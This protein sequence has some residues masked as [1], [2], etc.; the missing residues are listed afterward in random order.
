MP[1]YCLVTDSGARFSNQQRAIQ[2]YPLTI[3]PN[4]LQFGTQSYREDVDISSEE[5]FK[6][7][8]QQHVPPRVVAPT[9]QDYLD[10]YRSLMPVY[11]GIISIH[12][13]RDLSDSWKNARMASQQMPDSYPLLVVDSRQIC[14]GQGILVKLAAEAILEGFPFERVEAMVRAAIERIYSVYYVETLEY[15]R[16]NA[17]MSESRA[18]LGMMLGVKPFLSIEEGQLAVTEK[19]RTRAQAVEQIV[20]FVSEFEQLEDA[21]IVQSRVGLVEPARTIQ[22]RLSMAF[23]KQHFPFTLYSP[24]FAA[25]VGIEAVGVAILER[26]GDDDDDFRDHE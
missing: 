7:M 19:G 13:S 23:P 11:E 18:I 26:S 17:I 14:A 20:D 6:R 22:D 2:Y 24:S 15:L 8:A 12:T 3:I 4:L 5:A 25:L 1:K 21:L 10:I 9:V 16:H